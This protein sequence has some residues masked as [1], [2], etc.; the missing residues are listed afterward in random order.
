LVKAGKVG[1]KKER[2]KTLGHESPWSKTSVYGMI[3]DAMSPLSFKVTG[4]G[5]PAGFFEK[6]IFS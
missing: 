4:R 1:E 2:L 3:G 6:I 5:S